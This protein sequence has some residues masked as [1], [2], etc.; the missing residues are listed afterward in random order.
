MDKNNIIQI[1]VEDTGVGIPQHILENLFQEF[2]TYD[3]FNGSNKHGIGL[4]L[5][6]C[7]KLCQ[8]LGPNDKINVSSTVNVG[9]KF[10][11]TIQKRLVNDIT[12]VNSSLNFDDGANKWQN[13]KINNKCIEFQ[14]DSYMSDINDTETYNKNPVYQFTS[15]TSNFLKRRNNRSSSNIRILVADDTVYNITG[16]RGLL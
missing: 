1:S 4:G 10:S 2:S 6:I 11:F 9:S 12:H 15:E 8:V 16:I 13:D 7:K 14:T 3:H 5:S